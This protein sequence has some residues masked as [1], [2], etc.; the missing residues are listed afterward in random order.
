[1]TLTVTSLASGSSGNALLIQA[2]DAALLLDCG[3][4]ARAT[5]RLLRQRG[6]EPARLAAIL[7]THEHGD[8]SRGAPAL[9]RKYALP[10]VANTPT[11]DALAPE[12]HGVATRPLDNA[13]RAS[14]ASVAVEG[15]ALPHD[16]A[17]PL[18]FRVEYQGWSV[19]VAVDLGGWDEAVAAALADADLVVVEANHDRERLLAAPYPWGI[20]H[21]IMS[22]LGHLDNMS[23][24]ELI[25]RACRVGRV[26]TAWLGHLSEQANSPAIALKAVAA[27]LRQARVR[28]VTL[29]VAERGKPSACWSSANQLRQQTLW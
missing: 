12:L 25:A 8:H 17:A 29:A 22:P 2:G 9:C 21:R 18:G 5:E 4:S 14:V 26:R 11:L 24:G 7:L 1:M 3:L 10:L 23:A 28:D 15:F 20:K 16:A 13:N 19:A 27:C 6:V